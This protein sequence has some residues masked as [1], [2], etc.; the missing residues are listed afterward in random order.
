MTNLLSMDFP[1]GPTLSVAGLGVFHGV[2]PA[3]GWLF[4]VALAMQDRD[5][6]ALWRALG[7]LGIGHALAIAAAVAL[8]AIAGALVPDAL[9]R[10]T[11]ASALVTLGLSRLVRSRH[12]RAGGMRVGFMGLTAWS[13]LMASAHGAGLMVLPFLMSPQIAASAQANHMHHAGAA[14]AALSGAAAT[15]VHGAGYL[16][17][18]AFVAWIVY[19]KL[20]VGLIRRAWLNVDLVWAAALIVTG[21]LAAVA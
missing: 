20:G 19:E 15:L 6:R 1:L 3:M 2:N 21:L 14:S 18:T 7:A 13:F 8:T 17:A 16:V 10:V 11:I 9:I 4:A 5:R 12:P